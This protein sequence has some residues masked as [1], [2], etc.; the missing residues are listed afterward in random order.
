MQIREA[1]ESDLAFVAGQMKE[2]QDAHVEA[3]PHRYRAITS[4]IALTI[5]REELDSEARFVVAAEDDRLLGYAIFDFVD[6]VESRE[7]PL[8][9]ARRFC[10]L[11]QIGVDRSA[12]R[13][14]VGRA[15]VQ[16]VKKTAHEAGIAEIELKV[17][18][19]NEPARRFFLEQGFEVFATR[20]RCAATA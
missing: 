10:Y 9:K 4:E 5:L 11:W 17:W 13:Q 7:T 20:M 12:R 8:L 14:G 15:L 19:F 1:R 2:T 6:V 16:H 18:A 3:Y